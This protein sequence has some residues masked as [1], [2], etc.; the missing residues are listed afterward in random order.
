MAGDPY[1]NY[2]VL[3]LHCD[4]TDGSTRFVD[5]VT[6]KAISCIGN[7]QISTAQY[8]ALTGKTSSGL[9]DGNGDYLTIPNSGAWAFGSRD[10]TIRAR[11]RLAGYAS[12][13]SG[14][15]ASAIVTQDLSTSR[16]FLFAVTGTASSFTTLE[17][18]G[19]VDNST[20]VIVSSSFSFSLNTWYLVEACRI[21]NLIYLF[22]EGTLLNPGGTA[23]SITQQN[24]TT[25]LKI[26]ASMYDATY[27]YY[28]NGNIS[29]VEI[30]NGVGLHSASYTPSSDP[31]PD[32]FGELSG[33]TK[34]SSGSFAARLVRVYHRESGDFIGSAVSDATTGAWKIGTPRSGTHVAVA[35]G[36]TANNIAG[37]LAAIP[38][39][40][41]H[42]STTTEELGGGLVEL[43]SGATITTSFADPF[44]GYSGVLSMPSTSARSHCNKLL[45]AVGATGDFHIRAWV[46]RTANT[47]GNLFTGLIEDGSNPSSGMQWQFDT[48]SSIGIAR[49]WVAWDVTST[50][51]PSLNTWVYVQVRRKGSTLALFNGATQTNSVTLTS[52]YANA[53]G[54]DLIGGFTGY[55]CDLEV[56]SYADSVT[57]PT[58][59]L[60]R[61]ISTATENALIFDDIT[62]A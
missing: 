57:V 12:N 44:G 7:A 52:A 49:T 14:S 28:L 51:I 60:K 13:N 18:A 43:A 47:T 11:I 45:S 17:F 25:T 39:S 16:A 5:S 46:Y 8:P 59:R 34:D 15:Y 42:G 50:T 29:E 32:G 56:L 22:V 26:G 61:R 24:S 54:A 62:P 20:P 9:L 33:T 3:G 55:A 38:Y 21:G 58:E 31:F 37:R 10:F 1:W 23:Y 48:A 30:Y 6:G 53:T 36:G 40:G 2:K 19:F 4:G 41:T 27:L 35:H